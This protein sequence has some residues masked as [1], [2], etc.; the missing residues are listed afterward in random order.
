MNTSDN[1][2]AAIE[3][4][5]L[6]EW[7]EL[8]KCAELQEKIWG[9]SK[10]DILPAHLMKAY[11]DQEDVWGI[12]VGAF[13]SNDMVGFA[14]TLPTAHADTYLLH[15]IGILPEFQHRGIGDILIQRIKL[16][17]KGKKIKSISL[18]YDPLESVNANLYIRKQNGICRKY[19]TD[20]YE[21]HG[22]KTH[23]GF[24]ADRFRVELF[25]ESEERVKLL[26]DLK[27]GSESVTIEI[28]LNFQ[29]L[30]NQNVQNAID[31]REKTR[32][33]F[34]K[35]INNENYVVTD[36]IYDRKKGAGLYF[37]RR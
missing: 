24:A 29:Q 30:K 10:E 26:S 13:V 27:K 3:L 12:I 35:Y 6:S 22:S 18:T 4:R 14:I 28:P 32:S 37:L 25:V 1:Q 15:M 20:Y 5:E 11:C 33:L 34:S 9:L 23:S 16:L 2:A 36:F 8:E 21:F 19:L 31:L 7:S 17:A